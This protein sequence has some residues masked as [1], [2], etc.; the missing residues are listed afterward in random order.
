M[1]LKHKGYYFSIAQ[2]QHGEEAAF[3]KLEVHDW[4]LGSQCLTSD[5]FTFALEVEGLLGS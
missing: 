3:S 4:P 2:V 1:H 5:G